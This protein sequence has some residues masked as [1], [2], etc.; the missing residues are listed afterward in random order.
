[1]SSTK[2]DYYELLGVERGAT[3]AEIKKAYRKMAMKFHPDRNAGAKSGEA[4]E[5]F[6]EISE[7]YEV[8][9]DPS[10]RSAYDQFGHAGVDSSAG[11]GHGGAGVNFNDIFGD[12]FGD[13]FNGGQGDARRSSHGEQGADLRYHL[14]LSLEEAVRGKTVELQ[15]PT[16]GSC[17]GCKGSGAKAGSK[18]K[19]CD[20]C[21][22]VGQVRMQQGFFSI[23]QTCPACRGRGTIIADPCGKCS[24][25]GRI[26]Q[27]KKLSVQIP[28]G[29][30]TG[31]R[32]RLTGEG[33]AGL[34]GG[35]AGDL[36][37]EV[38]V[39]KHEIFVREGRDLYCE[40][41]ITFVS[42]ALGGEMDVPTLEGRVKLKIPA[43]TQTNQSFRI[44]AKGVRTLR[45]SS[46][47]DLFCRVIIETPVNLNK[48]QKELLEELNSTMTKESQ[49]N[50]P[51]S[52][53][54]FQKV[55]HF[56]DEAK[57]Q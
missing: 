43:G 45:S 50:S 9:S 53:S 41:P 28:E 36:Y 15:I 56:I 4:E 27:K 44:K 20:T 14:E 24:G 34:Q 42:A 51:K 6:K 29:V 32:I 10:K 13:I 54:W 7:A 22:G 48:R 35:P 47:G 23:Q 46:I 37:V 57:F 1:M 31:D 3:E 33:E 55:K 18:P 19:G 39:Y 16:W 2:A 11:G 25:Q 8:L 17:Q 40:V 26:H 5:K 21:G 38:R 12:I 49:D 52:T 30:D